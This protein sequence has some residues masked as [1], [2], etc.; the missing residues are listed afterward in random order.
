MSWTDPYHAS[1]FTH[2]QSGYQAQWHPSTSRSAP[3]DSPP[4]SESGQSSDSRELSR[5]VNHYYLYGGQG[6]SGGRGGVNGGGGGLGEGPTIHQNFIMAERQAGYA[7]RLP[8]LVP[9]P[10]TF[11]SSMDDYPHSISEDFM[12][13]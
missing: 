4:D 2:S 9:S 13:R 6:G 11:S 5:A 12:V 10:P 7:F 3:S 8:T 1:S